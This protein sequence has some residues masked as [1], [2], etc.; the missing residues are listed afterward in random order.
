LYFTLLSNQ[1]CI[2]VVKFFNKNAKVS[3]FNLQ[4]PEMQKF[5]LLFFNKKTGHYSMNRFLIF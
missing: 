2:I 3:L 1:V 4:F 5:L